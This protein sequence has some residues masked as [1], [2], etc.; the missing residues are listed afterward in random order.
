VVEPSDPPPRELTVDE[1]IALAIQLQQQHHLVEAEQLYA[2]VLDVAPHHPDAL[3][4]TGLLAHQQG[5]TDEAINLIGQSLALSPNQ[6]D[7]HSNLGI[8]LQSNGRLEDAITEYERAIAIDP[9]HAN[10]HSNLGV[11]L[12]AAGRPEKAEAAYRT[13]IRLCPDHVDAYTN[14]GILL[15][16]LKRAK[17]ASECFCR[18]ITLRPKHPEARRLLALAHCMIGEVD[19]AVKILRE[20]LE[21]DPDDP[22]AEHMLA[23]STGC[24]VPLRASNAFVEKTF[25]A[26]AVSFEAKLQS[27]AYRAPD[28]VAA[29]LADSGLAA[30]G[31]LEILDIGCGTGLCGPLLRPYAS[32]LIGVDLSAGMLA[33]AREKNVYTDLQQC[34][35]T[36]F[37]RARHEAFDVM[38]SA[39]TLVYFGDL[40][41]FCEAAASALRPS[42]LMVVTLEHAVG[43]DNI[44]FRLELHGRY[45][46]SL[47]YVKRVLTQS[48]LTAEA[49][50]AELRNEAGAPVAG[51]VVRATKPA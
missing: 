11:L 5:R 38:V 37:L 49:E 3:H 7:W 23:A 42:G 8:V 9:R 34:E 40:L 36:E 14:L 39:D 47:A 10:A 33:H 21:E 43:E 35:V 1:A 20:W 24:D 25:D 15:N 48:G 30:D 41:E 12:R 32:R 6:A 27:L 50:S 31:R 18:A 28:I 45:S 19:E 51:L 17:E 22:I 4:Y 2:Q 26:F 16:G 13:A 44:D 46:H 29:T